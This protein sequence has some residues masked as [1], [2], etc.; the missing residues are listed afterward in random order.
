MA[1]LV[2]VV[3]ALIQSDLGECKC[4]FEAMFNFGDS[5]TDTGGFYAAFPAQGGPYG[6]TY[7]QR[8][9]GRATD[10]RVITDFLGKYSDLTFNSHFHVT[11]VLTFT[12]YF[13]QLKVLGFHSWARTCNPLDQISATEPTSLHKHQQFLIHRRHCLLAASVHSL[14][15][16]RSGK[17]RRSKQRSTSSTHQVSRPSYTWIVLWTHMIHDTFLYCRIKS[18]T[19]GHLWKISAHILHWPKR[20]HWTTVGHRISMECPKYYASSSFP[21]FKRHQGNLC[22]KLPC[23]FLLS[24]FYQSSGNGLLLPCIYPSFCRKFMA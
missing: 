19:S 3:P 20:L 6:M 18:S 12:T 15:A 2:L 5:N 7:F 4:E 21:D 8:P 9:V 13:L 10:G 1:W 16:S 11:N 24:I 14:W 22:P 23:Y 17:W